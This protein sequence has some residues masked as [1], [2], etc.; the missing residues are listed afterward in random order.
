MP[1][2]HNNPEHVSISDLPME[3]EREEKRDK[4]NLLNHATPHKQN[5]RAGYGDI[6]AFGALG[7][8]G[9][10]V[11]SIPWGILMNGKNSH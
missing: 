7:E 9:L 5:R 1:T 10:I 8:L 6:N 3:G 11:Y 4:K 2:K